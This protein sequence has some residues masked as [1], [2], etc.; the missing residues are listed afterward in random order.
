MEIIG[1]INSNCSDNVPVH[2][3]LGDCNK[4]EGKTVALLIS[5]RNAVYPLEA[6]AFN[7]GLIGANGYVNTDSGLRLLPL[8]SIINNTPTGGDIATVDV[9]FAGPRPSG[10][11]A[12]SELYQ[13]D[14]GDCL[15]K[16]LAQLNKTRARVFRVDDQGNIYGT[17]VM[18]D[19]EKKFVG[20]DSYLMTQRT[21]GSDNSVIYSLSL[22]VY[23]SVD[24]SSIELPNLHSFV[25]NQ[26]PEG[27]IGVTLEKGPT[28]GTAKVVSTCD[29]QDYTSNYGSEWMPNMFA[30]VAGASPTTV[31]YSAS[32]GLLTFAP[33]AAYRIKSAPTLI[34]GDIQG[35][36]GVNNY[37]DLT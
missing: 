27:L 8:K 16:Q 35:L 4:Q 15:Y 33:I 36:E 34:A 30:N 24:Y 5:K 26:I 29:G 13:I 3:G 22:A 28:T 20:F 9:G 19:G 18:I 21:K 11:N 12:F 7:T 17:A 14:A 10:Y 37:V 32:T 6:A 25:V 23:Y 2:T 1:N 31:T